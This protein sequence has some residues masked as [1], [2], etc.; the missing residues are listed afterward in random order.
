MGYICFVPAI[1]DF[2]EYKKYSDMINDM[3]YEKLLVC[4]LCVV[5]TPEHIGISTSNRILQALD[6]GKPVYIWENDSLK[7]YTQNKEIK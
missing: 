6:L 1:Y 5:V 7:E 2:D 3:C 4:D